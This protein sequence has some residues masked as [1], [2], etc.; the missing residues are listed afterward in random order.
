MAPLQVIGMVVLVFTSGIMS[1]VAS[2]A[3][4]VIHVKNNRCELK[5]SS[6]VKDSTTVM[7]TSACRL[8][9]GCR[10]NLP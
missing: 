10:S 2:S 5:I 6:T 9:F 8:P 3:G 1:A 4:D 7:T